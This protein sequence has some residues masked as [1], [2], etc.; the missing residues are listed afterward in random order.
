MATKAQQ[1][2]SEMQRRAQKARPAKKKQV[3]RHPPGDS[4]ARNLK[5]RATK[6]N[7][8]TE[9]S[10]SGKPSRKSTRPSAQRGKNSTTLEYAARMRS[11]TP[12]RRH[13]AR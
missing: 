7:V 2:K 3:N 9:E 6:A 4:G 12:Q 10:R 1:F 11:I 5:A 8:A 13:Q